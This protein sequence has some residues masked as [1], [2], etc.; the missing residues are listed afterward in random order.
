MR[1][2]ICDYC[3]ETAEDGD[4]NKL[5]IDPKTDQPICQK[6]MDAVNDTLNDWIELENV[7]EQGC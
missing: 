5:I 3:P 6:C 2:H 4:E 7:G 1:C